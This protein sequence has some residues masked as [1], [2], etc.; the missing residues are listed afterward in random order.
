MFEALE[1]RSDIGPNSNRSQLGGDELG[2]KLRSENAKRYVNLVLIET[3][4]NFTKVKP[5][6]HFLYVLQCR[7][8]R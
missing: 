5:D 1:P 3:N 2:E 7:S 8:R 6:Y 4:V